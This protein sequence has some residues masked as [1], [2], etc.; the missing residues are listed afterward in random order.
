[1][2]S[3]GVWSGTK[4]DL[5][6]GITADNRRALIRENEAA[7]E[8]VALGYKVEQNPLKLAN[9]KEPD[10]RIGGQVFDCYAPSSSSASSIWI[11]IYERKISQGQ[12]NRIVLNLNDSSVSIDALRQEAIS[13]PM[14]GLEDIIVLKNG[15]VVPFWDFLH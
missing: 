8:L 1:M 5:P 15:Q 9:G 3:E 7:D 10:Y 12:T 11:N 13:N 14:P 4:T 6:D 2:P